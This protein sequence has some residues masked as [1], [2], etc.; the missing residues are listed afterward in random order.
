VTIA[1]FTPRGSKN[2]RARAPAFLEVQ[3]LAPLLAGNDLDVDRH[4]GAV[5]HERA[6]VGHER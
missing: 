5:G 3:L 4:G 2:S 6:P 1:A